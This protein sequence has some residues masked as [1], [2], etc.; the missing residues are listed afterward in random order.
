MLKDNK[1]IK[2]FLMGQNDVKKCFP[3][4]EELHNK[5]AAIIN[6]FRRLDIPRK[7]MILSQTM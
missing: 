1:L 2:E 6:Q 4:A 7:K 3:Y 5:K